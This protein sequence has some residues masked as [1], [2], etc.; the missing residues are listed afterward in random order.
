MLYDLLPAAKCLWSHARESSKFEVPV[1]NLPY[2]WS[3]GF[4]RRLAGIMIIITVIG[5]ND[6]HA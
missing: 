1:K 4:E 2:E 6:V 3:M 5:L